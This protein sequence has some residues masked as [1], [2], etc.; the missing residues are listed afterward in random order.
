MHSECDDLEH[1]EKQ[2]KDLELDSDYDLMVFV[3]E[4]VD[5]V[6]M[7]GQRTVWM[8]SNIS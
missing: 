3:T 4:F 7:G 8:I 6:G 5:V 1:S 2:S